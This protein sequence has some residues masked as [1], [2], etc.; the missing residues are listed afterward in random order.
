MNTCAQMGVATGYA[1]SLCIQYNASPRT[2]GKDHI[3]EVRE[4]VGY[5]S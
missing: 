4:I 3:K 1:A 5:S 2:I